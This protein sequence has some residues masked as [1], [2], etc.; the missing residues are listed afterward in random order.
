MITKDQAHVVELGLSQE[1]RE[2]ISKV[3]Q[4]Y[5]KDWPKDYLATRLG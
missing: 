5:D 1:N 2:D 3:Y 4:V